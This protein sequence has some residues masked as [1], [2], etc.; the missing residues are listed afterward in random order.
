MLSIIEKFSMISKDSAV[1]ALMSI[2]VE[3]PLG[4]V[5]PCNPGCANI[6]EIFKKIKSLYCKQEKEI[7]N[8][9][10]KSPYILEKD[11]CIGTDKVVIKKKLFEAIEEEAKKYFKDNFHKL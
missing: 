10:L 5:D 7:T 8:L 2:L 1:E 3:K 6:D 9:K 11:L 4:I